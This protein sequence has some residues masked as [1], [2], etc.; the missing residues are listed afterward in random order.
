MTDD[1]NIKPSHWP[2]HYPTPAELS[3]MLEEG[4]RAI[5]AR[6]EAF[7]RW[8]EENDC[9]TIGK[10]VKY[11]ENEEAE[12]LADAMSDFFPHAFNLY[13]WE[14]WQNA[15]EKER[16]EWCSDNL[17]D[18]SLEIENHVIGIECPDEAVMFKMVWR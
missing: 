15:S 12:E 3:R 16:V 9:E 13:K 4:C 14:T 17:T 5:A 11:H 10:L 8:C 1:P 18:Y 2:D 6:E 7:G